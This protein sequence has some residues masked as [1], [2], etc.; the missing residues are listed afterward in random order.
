MGLAMATAG[1]T[2]ALRREAELRKS[3]DVKIIYMLLFEYDCMRR[4]EIGRSKIVSS[5]KVVMV[6]V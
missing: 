2:I 6:G 4:G 5:G 1:N 3:L